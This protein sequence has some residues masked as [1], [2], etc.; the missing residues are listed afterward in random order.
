[1]D[2]SEIKQGSSPG[3]KLQDEPSVYDQV[4]YQELGQQVSVSREPT[5][6]EDRTQEKDQTKCVLRQGASAEGNQ[7]HC[8]WGCG[9]GGAV[10]YPATN[11]WQPTSSPFI[12]Q[13]PRASDNPTTEPS[14][15]QVMILQRPPIDG[16][17]EHTFLKSQSFPLHI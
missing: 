15:S 5:G 4:E 11:R 10:L 16:K 3:L 9:G 8:C 7:G 17:S 13:E 1:M 2:K 12:S 14:L 6:P